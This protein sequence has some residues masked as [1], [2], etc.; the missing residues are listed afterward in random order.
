M[1]WKGSGRGLI[2][3]SIQCLRRKN[4]TKILAQDGRCL[5]RDSNRGNQPTRVIQH[6]CWATLPCMR[7]VELVCE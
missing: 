7:T 6:Y 4:T 1:Y 3:G 2:C 5:S